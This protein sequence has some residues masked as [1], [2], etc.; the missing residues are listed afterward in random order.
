[1]PDVIRFLLVCVKGILGDCRGEGASF[2]RRWRL[3]GNAGVPVM[4]GLIEQAEAAINSSRAG[5]DNVNARE[6][7]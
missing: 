3:R 1:M 6:S 7:L 2:G 5:L 4:P